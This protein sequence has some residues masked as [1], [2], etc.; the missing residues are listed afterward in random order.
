MRVEVDVD[1]FDVLDEVP[2]ED[3][4]EEVAI[5]GL[6]V[7]TGVKD[8]DLWRLLAMIE[9]GSPGAA[10]DELREMLR[11]I[12]EVDRRREWDAVKSGEHPFLRAGRA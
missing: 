11:H 12:G 1:V 8:D 3:L 4:L 5:R 9:S 6:N 10:A 2:N 7:P